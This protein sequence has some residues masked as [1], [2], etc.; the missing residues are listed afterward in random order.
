MAFAARSPS[1]SAGSARSSATA[2]RADVPSDQGPAAVPH[3][4]PV[5]LR[6]AHAT[7]PACDPRAPTACDSG[8]RRDR[9]A[10]SAA[11]APLALAFLA[12]F[13]ELFSGA[14][15]APTLFSV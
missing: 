6:V 4:A 15:L 5:G 9:Q 7:G 2:A 11:L 3:G 14:P 13:S 8:L 10:A 1:S 12:G